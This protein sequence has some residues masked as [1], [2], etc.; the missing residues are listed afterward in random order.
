MPSGGVPGEHRACVGPGGTIVVACRGRWAG[1]ELGIQ[2]GPP[3]MSPASSLAPSHR[4]RRPLVALAAA[5]LLALLL[6]VAPQPAVN[7]REVAVAVDQKRVELT[8]NKPGSHAQIDKA[9][10]L[11]KAVPAGSRIRMSIYN[12]TVNSVYK[13]INAARARGVDVRVVANGENH[14]STLLRRL[15]ERMG[16]HFTW[17]WNACISS[18]SEGIMHAKYMLFSRTRDNSGAMRRHVVWVSSANFSGSG[19]DLSNNSVTTYGDEVLYEGYLTDVWRPMRSSTRW[20]DYYDSAS[21]RGYFGSA[22]S[23]TTVYVSPEGQY[24]LVYTRLGYINP[25]T[26]CTI[27]VMHNMVNDSRSAV[28]NR[29]VDLKKDGCRVLVAAKTIDPENRERFR[30]AGIPFKT[31]LKIHDKAI[32]VRARYDHSSS[33]RTVILTGSHNLSYSALRYNDELLVKLTDSTA[34]YKAFVSHFYAMY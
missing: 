10:R 18:H 16:S 25:G 1:K 21:G 31:R 30:D 13:A 2:K 3:L 22:A 32:I 23:N 20:S 15:A 24:D 29:L 7:A 19:Y 6:A 34:L 5:S 27:R 17:C 12:L 8:F 11:I 26:D 14:S 4:L 28:V 33:P 9:V